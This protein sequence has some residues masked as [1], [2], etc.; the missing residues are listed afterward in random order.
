MTLHAP[1]LTKKSAIRVALETDKGTEVD[2]TEDIYVENLEVN[3]TAPF[4]E[5]NGSGAQLGKTVAGVLGEKSG[6]CSFRT[7]LRGNGSGGLDASLAMLLQGCGLKQ[8]L[9]VYNTH[10]VFSDQETLSI[11]CYYDGVLKTLYGA[12]GNVNFTGQAGNTIWCEFTFTGI[13]KDPE[14][15]ALITPAFSTQPE[16]QLGSATWSLDSQSIK[17]DNFGLSLENNVAL[18]KD[19][20][21]Y[22]GI[23]SAI[24]SDYNPTLTID[25]EFDLVA[26]Y[27]YYTKWK[28]GATCAVSLAVSD[29]T[30]DITFTLPAVQY[31]ELSPSDRDGTVVLDLTGH[32]LHS[33][34]NDAVKIEASASV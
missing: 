6:T 20:V 24:I 4:E 11:D 15:A 27:D 3:A 13:W 21:G 9:E 7:P 32:C 10:S 5:R 16:M 19:I 18:R 17:I 34:G 28:S 14:D 29:G 30:D 33:A 1:L 22:G 23:A 12:M 25:P 31:T 2:G 8:T 26:G